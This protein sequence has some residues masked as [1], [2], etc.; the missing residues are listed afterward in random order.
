M[1]LANKLIEKIP[2]S[3]SVKEH[4]QS[5][6][7]KNNRK[8][9]KQSEIITYE[10]NT[11]DIVDVKLVITEHPKTSHKLSKTIDNDKKVGLIALYIV[12]Q[13]SEKNFE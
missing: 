3:R 5:F 13:K 8:S 11:F 1:L 7:G 10:L 9:V 12:I 4:Y 6:L 2:D